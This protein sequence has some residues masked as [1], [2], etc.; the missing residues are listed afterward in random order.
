MLRVSSFK[1]VDLKTKLIGKYYVQS[2]KEK[3]SC[4]LKENDGVT[5]NKMFQK[6]D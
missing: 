6:T 5:F 1:A 2:K 4:H 3:I